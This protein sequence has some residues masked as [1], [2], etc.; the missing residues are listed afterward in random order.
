MLSKTKKR[1]HAHK[2][3]TMIFM[4]KPDVHLKSIKRHDSGVPLE[5]NLASM[6]QPR[7]ITIL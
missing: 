7:D 2:A 6:S 3:K 1:T 4:R 5:L